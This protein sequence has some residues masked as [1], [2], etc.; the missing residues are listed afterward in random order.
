MTPMP[1]MSLLRTTSTVLRSRS[2]HPGKCWVAATVEVGNGHNADQMLRDAAE[3]GHALGYQLGREALEVLEAAPNQVSGY[4][5]SAL[6]GRDVDPAIAAAMIH[7]Q[8]GKSLR[9]VL[10]GGK[11]LIPSTLKVAAEG[12]T[13]DIPLHGLA[14]EWDF[15]LLDSI[16]AHVD[17]APRAD[18]VVVFVALSRIGG[19]LADYL[20]QQ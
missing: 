5:K 6:V 1:D 3:L 14:D 4:G 19:P 8:L 11:S 15:S 13:I 16:E 7:L 20:Q 17:G 9:E 2:D 12:T 10:G 18:Q